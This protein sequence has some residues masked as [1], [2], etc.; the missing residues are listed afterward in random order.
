[1][2]YILLVIAWITGFTMLGCLGLLLEARIK[3]SPVSPSVLAVLGLVII[4]F[5]LAGGFYL[6]VS[7]LDEQA[8]ARKEWFESFLFVLRKIEKKSL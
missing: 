8:R 1:M 6:V 2:R 5:I 3:N 4:P 7:I